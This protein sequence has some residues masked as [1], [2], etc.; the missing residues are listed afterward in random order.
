[1]HAPS[2]RRRLACNLYES[3][4]LIAVLFVVAFPLAAITQHLPPQIGVILLRV[5]LLLAAGIYFT[6]FWRKGQTLAMKTWGIRI[7]ASDGGAPGPVQVWLRYALA[8]LNLALLGVGWW[9]ALLRSDRQFLQDR[10]AGTRLVQQAATCPAD[11]INA[12]RST[13]KRQSPPGQTQES[14]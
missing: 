7:V 13:R 14:E 8:C 12:V 3:L 9:A 10:Y 1:V 4:L 5:Y 2:L 11:S 6:L